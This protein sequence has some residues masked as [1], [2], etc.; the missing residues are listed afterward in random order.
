MRRWAKNSDAACLI[1]VIVASGVGCCPRGR[2]C[3]CSNAPLDGPKRRV[4]QVLR[5]V[6][7]DRQAATVLEDRDPAAPGPRQRRNDA[8]QP[9]PVGEVRTRF[10]STLAPQ[11]SWDARGEGEQWTNAMPRP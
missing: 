3:A 5:G 4:P 11:R 6:G 1:D 7:A 8:I 2:G 10:P 9:A